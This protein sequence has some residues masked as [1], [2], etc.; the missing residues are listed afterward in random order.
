MNRNL[1]VLLPI[2][3]KIFMTIRVRFHPVIIEHID[4]EQRKGLAKLGPPLSITNPS[5]QRSRNL[6]PS[7][8]ECT[9]AYRLRIT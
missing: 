7:F 2:H 6:Q 4:H 1:Q 3:V 5:L 8:V 9:L